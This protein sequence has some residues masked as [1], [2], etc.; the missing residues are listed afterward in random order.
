[1]VRGE[2]IVEKGTIMRKVTFTETGGRLVNLAGVIPTDWLYIDVSLQG[3]ATSKG[4]EGIKLLIIP[5]RKV[6]TAVKHTRKV[7]ATT[8]AS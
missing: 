1:M 3:K 7:Q 5:I 6:A 2:N 4:A 8:P